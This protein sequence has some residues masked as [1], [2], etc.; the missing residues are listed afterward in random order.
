[1]FLDESSLIIKDQNLYTAHELA[2]SKLLWDRDKTYSRLIK[3]NQWL[4]KYLP[5]WKQ[6]EQGASLRG[7]TSRRSLFNKLLVSGLWPLET[8][9]KNLQ[10]VYMKSKVTTEKIGKYQLF[11]H[12]KSTQELVLGKYIKNLKKLK[13]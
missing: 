7:L 4:I 9:L 3:A 2:Q 6:E 5:N 13:I 11:F 8:I 12:P 1:L 10:L